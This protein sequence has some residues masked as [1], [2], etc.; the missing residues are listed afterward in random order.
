M[1]FTLSL[2]GVGFHTS[3]LIFPVIVAI[4]ALFILGLSLYLSAL[5]VLYRDV[6]SAL[7]L[8]TLAW[9]YVTPIIYPINIAREAAS[10]WGGNSAFV[11]YMMNPMAAVVAGV[12]RSVL[13]PSGAEL[14]DGSLACFLAAATGISLV[15]VLTGRVLFRS[16]SYQFADEL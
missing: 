10:Q 16:L 1:V 5:N 6:G 2:T 7:E 13:Y 8:F 15:L 14:G 4:A 3:L 9:F 11:L 12:R